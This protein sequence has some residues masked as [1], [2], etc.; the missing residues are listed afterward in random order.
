MKVERGYPGED[1]LTTHWERQSHGS[2]HYLW[3]DP[4]YVEWGS[5]RGTPQSDSSERILHDRLLE[6]EDQD[7]IA[8]EFGSDVLQE[9]LYT[10]RHGR[11]VPRFLKE[12]RAAKTR[13]G[14]CNAIPIDRTLPILGAST[15]AGRSRQFCNVGRERVAGG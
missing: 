15:E 1:R 2:T 7:R 11:E 4:Y 8:Q 6:G 5:H 14:F 13:F 3:I 9:V 10:V 12:W